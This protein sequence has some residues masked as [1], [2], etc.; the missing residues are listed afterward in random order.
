MVLTTFRGHSLSIK[1]VE[2]EMLL[3]ISTGAPTELAIRRS[4]LVRKE[5]HWPRIPPAT[6]SVHCGGI[7]SEPHQPERRIVH[8]QKSSSRIDHR[9]ALSVVRMF[10]APF[11]DASGP[12]GPGQ[13]C[14]IARR[15]GGWR[16]HRACAERSS[17]VRACL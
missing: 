1:V 15:S 13:S 14:R 16:R 5:L 10:H 8:G 11:P 17:L 12:A 6:P 7:R 3:Q 4:L 2:E 9:L